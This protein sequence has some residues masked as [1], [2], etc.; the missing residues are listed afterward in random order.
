VS[1]AI[2]APD[3]KRGASNVAGK[4][5]GVHT[6][7]GNGTAASLRR[8]G[9]K[10]VPRVGKQY[11]IKRL[12]HGGVKLS[13]SLASENSTGTKILCSGA[14]KQSWEND[15]TKKPLVCGGT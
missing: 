7:P 8:Q 12:N 13:R 4:K 9:F 14:A 15:Q 3:R 2:T 11:D 1:A 10:G 5:K 6:G